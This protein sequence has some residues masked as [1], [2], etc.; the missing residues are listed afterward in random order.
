M[1]PVQREYVWTVEH[2]NELVDELLKAPTF[3]G[4][5]TAKCQGL[6]DADNDI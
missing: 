5:I 4:S 6:S 3:L 1:S 2:V